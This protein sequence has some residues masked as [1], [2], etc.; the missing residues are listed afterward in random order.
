MASPGYRVL[1]HVDPE[2]ALAV[3]R[4]QI[5]TLAR[6]ALAS[7]EVSVP[8][9]LSVVVTD[10]ETVRELNRRYRHVDAPTDVLSFGMAEDRF[11]VPPGSARQLGEIVISYPTAR[12]QAE[13]AGRPVE[14][15]LAHLLVHG[16]LH[17][18]GYDH[19][20]IAEARWSSLTSHTQ[21]GNK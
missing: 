10:D 9:V 17:L 16:L 8:A 11:I 20:S 2:F 19:E 15:E 1:V 5:I 12:R 18:L 13:E 21:I 14:N 4:R 7:D 6:R 3:R